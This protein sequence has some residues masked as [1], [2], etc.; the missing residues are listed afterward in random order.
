MAHPDPRIGTGSLT[1]LSIARLAPQLGDDLVHLAQAGGA[2]RLA[3]RDAATVGV[4]RQP[5]VDL[6]LAAS[7]HRHLLAVLAEAALGEVH[8]LRAALGVL[9]LG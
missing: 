2:D 3:V 7:N 4:D 5:A 1:D 9:Q 8:D 6:S